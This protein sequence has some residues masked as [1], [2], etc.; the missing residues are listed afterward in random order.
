M[1]SARLWWCSGRGAPPM[2]VNRSMVQDHQ[3]NQWASWPSPAALQVGSMALL[4]DDGEMAA[5]RDGKRT[6]AMSMH[7]AVA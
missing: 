6:T 7:V 5:S 1:R 4:P 3:A 2:R